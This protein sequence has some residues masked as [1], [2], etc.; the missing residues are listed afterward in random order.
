VFLLEAFTA[1]VMKAFRFTSRIS[2]EAKSNV[3]GIANAQLENFSVFQKIKT[4]LCELHAARV[5]LPLN[6]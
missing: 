5:F 3:S 6:S 1:T 4:G 2:S